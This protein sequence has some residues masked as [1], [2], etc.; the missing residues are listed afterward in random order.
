MR[1]VNLSHIETLLLGFALSLNAGAEVYKPQVTGT[2]QQPAVVAPVPIQQPQLVPQPS[3]VFDPNN[4][5]A[6]AATNPAIVNVVNTPKVYGVPQPAVT[7]PSLQQS[8]PQNDN[9]ALMSAF[10]ALMNMFGGGGGGGGSGG[11]GRS[12]IVGSSGDSGSNYSSGSG[13]TPVGAGELT[14]MCKIVKPFQKWFDACT[15]GL[16]LGNCRFQNMGIMGD[17]SHR[18]RASCHNV[19]EAIDV[20]TVT[21]SG[22]Q[23]LTTNSPEF[24]NL[25]NCMANDSQNE[26]QVIFYK[27][28]GPNMIQKSDH[29]NHMHIQLK[30]CHM[31]VGG[32]GRC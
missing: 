21:C 9:Q 15:K 28:S 2:V 5:N 27:A 1:I 26:L 22:G 6:A 32:P 11:G 3:A 31:V 14:G 17:A 24:F 30:N 7:D 4:P 29:T 13:F 25:A 18:A 10:G 8:L 19:G 16:G 12:D 20:G 23:K